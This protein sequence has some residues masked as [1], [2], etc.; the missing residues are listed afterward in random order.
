M[1]KLHYN[2]KDEMQSNTEDSHLCLIT[3]QELQNTSNTN[4]T[5]EKLIL[6]SRNNE[7]SR[8]ESHEDF[9]FISLHIY[10]N[11]KTSKKQ[12]RICIYFTKSLLV[13]ACDSQ[14]VLKD[15]E[16]DFQALGQK[17]NALEKILQ[18]FFNKLTYHDM[19]VLE[20]LEQGI[21][22]LEDSLITSNKKNYVKEI[23]SFRKRLLNLKR[24]YEHLFS[25]LEDLQENQNEL[26]S[27]KELRYFKILTNRVERL[28]Q[29]VLHLRDYVTQVREAYQAQ[30]DI[31]ANNI[32]KLFTV[33]TSV[34]LPLS[35]IAGW[36]GMNLKMP[37]Y[38]L[39]YGYPLV[40]LVSL[41]VVAL[42]ITLFKK[43]KWF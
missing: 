6:E 24:Y 12:V 1:V 21:S 18:S 27:K 19:N 4:L 25:I 36:Y 15:V 9:D 32:M 8:F 41:M 16:Q 13:L 22:E 2:L 33:I 31:E 29:E 3:L 23:V 38:N 20:K 42:C 26:I 7:I 28:L 10:D 43:N 34:F 30:V 35:L 14:K 37:E 11:L 17:N 5:Y 39:T 40:I